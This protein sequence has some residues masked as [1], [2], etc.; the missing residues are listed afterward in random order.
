M[1]S[2]SSMSSCE[3]P[4]CYSCGK[5]GHLSWQCHKRKCKNTD[6]ISPTIQPSLG[7]ASSTSNPSN[8]A[9]NQPQNPQRPVQMGQRGMERS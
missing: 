3:V 6:S 7:N 1:S 8:A 9:M 4:T 5:R 2:S